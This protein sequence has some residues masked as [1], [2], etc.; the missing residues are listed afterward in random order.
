[1][2][3][4]VLVFGASRRKLPT[5]RFQLG[6]TAVDGRLRACK[7]A[8]SGVHARLRLRALLSKLGTPLRN[9]LGNARGLRIDLRDGRF[10]LRHDIVRARRLR[11]RELLDEHRALSH[12]GIIA[13]LGG[14]ELGLGSRELLLGSRALG[15]KLRPPAIDLRLSARK[16]ASTRVEG[17]L[18][19]RELRGRV[20]KLR[21]RVVK[22]RLRIVELLERIGSLGL[23]VGTAL[24][25]FRLRIGPNTVETRGEQII[26]NAVN[27]RSRRINEQLVVIGCPLRLTST[28]DGNERL[29]IGEILREGAFGNI[30]ESC[31]LPRPERR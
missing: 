15:F 10:E 4:A 3:E 26:R 28:S 25:K 17:R 19:A 12:G 31:E 30:S 16:I 1:M 13:R 9:L 27:A 21:L 24:V 22:F 8:L 18:R 23:E 14:V 5:S 2:R 29:G 7:L 20:V 11:L 6:A